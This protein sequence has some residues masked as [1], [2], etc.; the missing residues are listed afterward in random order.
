MNYLMML[1]FETSAQTGD[2]ITEVFNKIVEMIY[3]Y[4]RKAT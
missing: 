2:G 3:D 1:Y 4:Y